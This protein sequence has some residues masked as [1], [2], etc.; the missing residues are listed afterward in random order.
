MSPKSAAIYARTSRDPSGERL[1][2]HRQEADCMDEA[3]RRD[4][5]GAW[6]GSTSTTISARFNLKK[7]RPE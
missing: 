1:G 4:A 6:L 7:S 5:A 2:V 3:K